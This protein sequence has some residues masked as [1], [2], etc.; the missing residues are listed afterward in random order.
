MKFDRRYF[1]LGSAA[2]AGTIFSDRVLAGN[3]VLSQIAD[4][5]APLAEV[6]EEN[7]RI[8]VLS[9]LNGRYGS[10]SY[11]PTVTK[12]IEVI[13]KLK[14]DLIL[15]AGDAIAGQKLSLTQS[16]I[17]A[18]W[19]SFDRNIAVPIANLKIPFA[20]TIG[21]HDGSG[22]LVNGK[23]RYGLDRSLAARY[24]NDSRRNL[25]LNFVDRA[26]FP[27]Y[28]SFVK[29]DLF[30]LI[31]DASTSIISSQQLTWID[32]ALAS[33]VARRA[34]MR[35]VMGHLP[36][37]AVSV[38]RDRPGEYLANAEKLHSLLEK[39]RVHTYVSGHHHAYYPGKKGRLELLNA[40]ALGSGPKQLLNSNLPA[41]S[42]LTIIDA[43]LAAGKTKY[44]TYDLKTAE[45]IKNRYLPAQIVATNS[46]IVRRDL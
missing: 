27:F 18:M 13:P 14:P 34:K 15:C 25:G 26:Q 22:A 4:D 19:A 38:G 35:I 37:Y 16:Q 21:N 46:K 41:R 1:L 33:N 42:T 29:K 23:Y 5:F 31:W 30:F 10:T 11:Q 12:A 8:L 2:F 43:D 36:L 28:Y 3:T 39:Y 6:S 32:R 44:T 7:L 45:I 9:D 20:T 24:W 17:E 40:G